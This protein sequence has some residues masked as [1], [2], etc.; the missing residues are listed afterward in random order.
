MRYTI[1]VH[2]KRSKAL[3]NALY[4]L[5]ENQSLEKEFDIVIHWGVLY[6]LDN[7]K[8]DLQISIRHGKI[9]FLESEVCDS[10]DPEIEIKVN[11]P[12]QYDQAI[13]RTGSRPSAEMVEK[14]ISETGATFIRYDDSDLNSDSHTYDWPVR[15][16]KNAPAGQR[17]FWIIK[18]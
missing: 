7:W 5:S 1:K 17:R 9:I 15:N 4:K 3:L 14:Y 12:E 10:N 8:A 16:T 2:P 13:G 6:H 18:K 11:E